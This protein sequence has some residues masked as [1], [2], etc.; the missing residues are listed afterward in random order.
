MIIALFIFA[1][2][3]NFKYIYHNGFWNWV[4][5]G[6]V[7]PTA[8][9]FAWP[10]FLFTSDQKAKE[11]LEN[12][13]GKDKP[14]PLPPMNANEEEKF[15]NIF[16]KVADSDISDSNLDTIRGVIKGYTE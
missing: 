16:S 4:N 11:V 2:Y 9:A 7:V 14:S 13:T 1:T 3:Y 15:G 6:E 10:Y 12:H 8:A 5:A